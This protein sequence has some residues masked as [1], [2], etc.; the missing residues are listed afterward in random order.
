M[1]HVSDECAPPATT[2]NSSVA[3]PSTMPRDGGLC[4]AQRAAAPSPRR[5]HPGIGIVLSPASVFGG[6]STLPLYG[7]PPKRWTGMS[8]ART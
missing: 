5:A 8:E 6:P 4:F 3:S 1:A 7:S 2:S